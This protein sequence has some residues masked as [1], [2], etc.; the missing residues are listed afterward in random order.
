MSRSNPLSFPS[1]RLL[2]TR[3][4]EN[5]GSQSKS[6]ARALPP[7]VALAAAPSPRPIGL[8]D[9]RL[10][11]PFPTSRLGG[12]DPLR[13]LDLDRLKEPP[14]LKLLELR[15][16]DLGGRA[17]LLLIGGVRLLLLLLLW[18]GVYLSLRRPGGERERDG[19]RLIG[20]GAR[21]AN[22]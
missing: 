22:L 13:L 9:T 17:A 8:L 7:P 10:P 18:L 19:L 2:S 11:F 14:P 20:R 6:A 5:N 3:D 4:L 12:D 1:E 21:R 16:F 15:L